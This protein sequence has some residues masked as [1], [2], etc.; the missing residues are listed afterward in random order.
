MA[1]KTKTRKTTTKTRKAKACC[2]ALAM[3]LADGKLPLVE[4]TSLTTGQR[5]GIA[6]RTTGRS[7]DNVML[8]FCPWCGKKLLDVGR[9]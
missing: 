2:P 1:D 9:R 4:I 5:L 7:P 6:I 8:E 3:L